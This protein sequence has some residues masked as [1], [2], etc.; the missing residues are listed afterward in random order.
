M[1]DGGPRYTHVIQRYFP[2]RG[3]S[4]RYFQA[5]S[6]RFARDGARVQVVTSDAWDL[7]YFWDPHAGHIDGRRSEHN[8]VSIRRVPVHHLPVAALTHR[9]IRRMMAESGRL[10]VPGRHTFLAQGSRFGP[11]LP[12]LDSELERA[13]PPDL[14]NSANIAFES[15]IVAAERY[16]R[17]HD[18]PHI[19]TPFLHVGET[20]DSRV[21]RYYTM[22][23]QIDLLRRAD[24]V[25]LLTNVERDALLER[26]LDERKLHIVGAGIDVESVTGGDA[27]AARKRLAIDGAIVLALGAAAFDKGT[28]HLI[29][30]IQSLRRKGEDVHLVIAGPMMSDVTPSHRRT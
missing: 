1:S 7:E 13:G 26:G 25:M 15:M 27:V 9:A 2:F 4:E 12:D 28:I 5:F 17:H 23:H 6:E 8:G 19:V 29:E 21:V 14:V 24:A 3:G 30:A 18:V 16:A 11:W 20:D 22:P 10:P